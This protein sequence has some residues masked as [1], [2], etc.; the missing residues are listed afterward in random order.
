MISAYENQIRLPSY[1][2]L[3][4]IAAYF[5]VSVDFLLSDGKKIFL[6]ITELTE[7]QIS[8]LSDLIDQF[9]E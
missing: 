9:K 6:E 4:K 3:L 1:D 8:L 7:K 2:V 5:H